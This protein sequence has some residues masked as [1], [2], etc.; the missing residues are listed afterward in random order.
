MRHG[1]EV[2]PVQKKENG[3]VEKKAIQRNTD[4]V[5]DYTQ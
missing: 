4:D 2:A 1:A 3:L 5:L